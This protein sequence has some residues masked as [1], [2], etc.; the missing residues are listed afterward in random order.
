MYD[1]GPRSR[2]DTATVL[3]WLVAGVLVL[4]AILGMTWLFARDGLV[5]P[6]DADPTRTAGSAEPVA[7]ESGGTTP[8][9]SPGPGPSTGPGS[10]PSP[11]P[12]PEPPVVALTGAGSGR[13]LDVPG[14]NFSDGVTLQI[15]DC[16][17]SAAQ[18]W[19]VTAAGEVRIGGT[20]CLDDASGGANG[21]AV[22]IHECHGGANQRWSAPGDGTVRSVATGLCLD[23]EA[24][25]TENGS[26]VNV[27][28][29]HNGP[30]QLWTIG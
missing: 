6:A 25:G 16:N 15:F 10:R 4:G 5:S 17:G 14:A 12:P 23:V 2:A 28:Q 9:A 1:A 3:T 8:S 30:N 19:T 13:C 24:A 26:P 29:C 20:K 22:A 27:Y 11:S 21:T 18:R 7:R